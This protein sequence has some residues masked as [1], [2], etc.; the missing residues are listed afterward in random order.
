MSTAIDGRASRL[1]AGR[2]ALWQAS[3]TA[4]LAAASLVSRRGSPASILLGACVLYGSLLLQHLAVGFAL[5]ARPRPELAVGLFLL[6][7][8]L[9]LALVAIGLGTS[10]VAP[11]SFAVG[12]STLLLA[13][14]LDAC[15]PPRPGS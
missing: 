3:A 9:L 15:Y 12:A 6:K 13:I 14:V 5:R 2:I 1:R 7:L 4:A 8:S 11:M 10:V